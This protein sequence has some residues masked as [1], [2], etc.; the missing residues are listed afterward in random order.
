MQ[1]GDLSVSFEFK[2]KLKEHGVDETTKMNLKVHLDK[3]C[4]YTFTRGV[5]SE[6]VKQ[7]F[8]H[9]H[10]QVFGWSVVALLESKKSQSSLIEE[11]A[12]L[13]RE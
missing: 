6:M 2:D 1:I 5:G 8:K 13:P 4:A 9:E 12:E 7:L 11:P 3:N 10:N